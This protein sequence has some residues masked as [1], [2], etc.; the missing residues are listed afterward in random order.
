MAA[1]GES[2]RSAAE[3]NLAT[4]HVADGFI[5][6]VHSD[7]AEHL[8]GWSEKSNARSPFLDVL[9]SFV[10]GKPFSAV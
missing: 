9:A 3:A 5:S 6:S 10:T 7:A 4:I 8:R 2:G 1:I